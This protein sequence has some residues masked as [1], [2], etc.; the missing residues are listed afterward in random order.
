ITAIINPND[1]NFFDLAQELMSGKKK[2]IDINVPMRHADGH[3]VWMRIRAEVTEEEEPHLVGISYDISEQRQFAEQTA[4][5]DL[6][7]RD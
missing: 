1:A 4:Q 3:Y 5:A 6:R 7:I 2:H